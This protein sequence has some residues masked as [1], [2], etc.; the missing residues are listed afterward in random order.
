MMEWLVG[1]LRGNPELAIFLALGAGYWLGAIKFGSFSLGSVTGTLLAGILVGQLGIDI[2]PQVKSVFFMLFLFAVGYGVGPQFVRGVARDGV[3]QALFAVVICLLTLASVVVASLVA[4]YDPGF[5]AGLHAGSQTI[6]ASIGLATDAINGLDASAGDKQAMLNH[7]PVAYAVTYIWGTVGTG[8]IL[9]TL[10][11]KLL[12]VDLAAECRRYEKKLGAVAGGEA[13]QSAWRRVEMRAYRIPA[14]APAV[15]KSVAAAERLAQGEQDGVPVR[16]FIE[17]IRRDGQIIQLKPETVLEME[18]R[19]SSND[20]A[21]DADPDDD[22]GPAAPASYLPDLRM[23]PSL[24]LERTDSA[25]NEREQL[26]AALDSLDERS[27]T[28]LEA[29][30]LADKKQ[31]LHELAER[32]GVSAERIRQI[33]KN[34]LKKLRGQLAA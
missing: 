11:P 26:Y 28:I 17:R 3:P 2:S 15:G 34:A 24:Q 10:G 4:G 1:T 19:M 32:Y 16:M 21:F 25:E 18:A 5:A 29:R 30:W 20:V 22:E 33:E 13:A 9:A 12:R 27:R 23:E 6:S 14:G 31:T 8:W 7:I